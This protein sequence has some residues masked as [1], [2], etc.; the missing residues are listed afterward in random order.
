MNRRTATSNHCW[1]YVLW[2]LAWGAMGLGE[3]GTPPAHGQEIAPASAE[4]GAVQHDYRGMYIDRRSNQVRVRSS[5]QAIPL[6]EA[7]EQLMQE[8]RDVEEIWEAIRAL[9]QRVREI[10]ADVISYKLAL[11][12]EQNDRI[13]LHRA[14]GANSRYYDPE[15]VSESLQAVEARLAN[16]REKIEALKETRDQLN[17]NISLL[18][19]EL[20]YRNV[21]SENQPHGSSPKQRLACR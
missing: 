7:M 20:R 3:P 6:D 8:G 5:R 9:R 16:N 2:S 21:F 17:S 11:E 18:E 4:P 14:R 1:P 19:S 13:A 15:L 12:K 10:S